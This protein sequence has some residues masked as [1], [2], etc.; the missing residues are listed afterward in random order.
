MITGDS[1]FGTKLQ[2][3]L[4]VCVKFFYLFIMSRVQVREAWLVALSR[5]PVS[6]SR[7][8]SLY[9]L[10]YKYDKG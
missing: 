6:V 5:P 1:R 7:S 9:L 8:V 4:H 3:E 2:N 10:L